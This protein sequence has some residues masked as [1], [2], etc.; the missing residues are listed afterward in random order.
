MK[1]IFYT[2]SLL[3][4]LA[5]CTDNHILPPD[6]G[7]ARGQG[8]AFTTAVAPSRQ[9]TEDMTTRADGSLVNRLETQLPTTATRTYYLWNNDTKTV[10][11]KEA[12]YYVGIYGCYTKDS[13][14]NDYTVAGKKPTAN[15]FYNQKASVGAGGVLS[16]SPERFWPNAL[17]DGETDEYQRASFWAYYPW[18]EA[19]SGVGDYGISITTDENGVPAGGGM[20]K[21]KFTMHPDAAEQNDFLISELTADCSKDLY[22]LIDDGDGGLTPKRVPLRFHHMLAQVRLYAFIRGTDRLVYADA[23]ADGIDDVAD[24]TWF[25]SW[26]LNGTIMDAYGNVF[27][28]KGADQVEQT[29]T[30]KPDLTKAEFVALG[31]KVPDEAKSVR[32]KRTSVWDVTHSRRRSDIRYSMSFNNIHTQAIYEP[33]ITYSAGSYT[34][35]TNITVT[36]AATGS[37]TVNH[38]IMNPYWFRFNDKGERVM[39]NENYMYDYFE[40]TKG[41]NKLDASD[42]TEDGRDWSTYATGNILGYEITGTTGQE[43]LD[44]ASA[45]PTKHYNYAPGNIL[46]VVP[47]QLTDDDVPNIVITATGLDSNDNP[48]TAKVTI[49]MLQMN[50]KWEAGFIYC[51]AFVDE[52][53]PGDDKVRGPETITV[54]FDPTRET[55]QW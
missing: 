41:Y 24:G 15:F 49:N 4:V 30:G 51:Y 25:D 34:T 52:L 12:A 40:D 29:T 43:L 1:R 17:R 53:M 47:Q 48:V 18:N 3:A 2:V 31:L 27:T 16:Y 46:L 54:V 10:T 42:P 14:W 33:T 39:L 6:G 26:T 37:A 44:R 13:L 5:S 36:D 21:V 32:W 55:D 35:R 50:L 8:I 22:P 20:G 11:A 9:A 28:K 45:T 7:N 38:Y 23:N 19:A